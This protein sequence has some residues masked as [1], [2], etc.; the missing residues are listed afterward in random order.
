MD[1][2]AYT[3]VT[4]SPIRPLKPVSAHA[5]AYTCQ[6]G[7][8]EHEDLAWQEAFALNAGKFLQSFLFS[9]E[10]SGSLSVAGQFL[11]IMRSLVIPVLSPNRRHLVPLASSPPLSPSP[12][13]PSPRP[14]CCRP[15]YLSPCICSLSLPP[16]SPSLL[17]LLVLLPVPLFTSPCF[18]F[19]F[20]LLLFFFL[21]LFFYWGEQSPGK[22]GL[23]VHH[24]VVKLMKQY[25]VGL[26]RNLPSSSN[27]KVLTLGC[28]YRSQ[29][30]PPGIVYGRHVAE[31]IVMV[32]L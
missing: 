22:P 8:I 26:T 19:S 23:Q 2:R 9:S 11:R 25:A 15:F 31:T 28:I 30:V 14:S 18:S 21:W 16:P 24:S 5:E 12:C 20:C 13:P 27:A 29:H 10:C 3:N 4:G 17:L 32:G 1:E 6:F 7:S